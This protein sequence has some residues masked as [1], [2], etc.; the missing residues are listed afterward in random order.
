MLKLRA[1]TLK[2]SYSFPL[3]YSEI[4]MWVQIP[5]EPLKKNIQVK[6]N[7]QNIQIQK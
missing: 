7:G 6:T 1:Y 4:R 5:P 3:G 2:D